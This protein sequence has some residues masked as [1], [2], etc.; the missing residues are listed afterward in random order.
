MHLTCCSEGELWIQ[1]W[2]LSRHR[3]CH[4][5]HSNEGAWTVDWREQWF[6]PAWVS[7][8]LQLWF[9]DLEAVFDHSAHSSALE[10]MFLELTV[11]LALEAAVQTLHCICV[12]CFLSQLEEIIFQ[13]RPSA[14]YHSLLEAIF[15]L[16]MLAQ[17]SRWSCFQTQIIQNNQNYVF[18]TVGCHGVFNW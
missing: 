11:P 18:S 14:C 15:L 9:S 3:C 4:V 1:L 8:L 5:L 12:C 17:A 10:E 13:P 6:L 16:G 2:I 7:Q